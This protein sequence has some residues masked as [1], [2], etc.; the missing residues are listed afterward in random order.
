MEGNHSEP[1]LGVPS[2]QRSVRRKDD[3]AWRYITERTEQNGKKTLICD[4]CQKESGGGG[5]NRMKQHLAGIRGN[6]DSCTKVSAEVQF[7][8][9]Q[10]LKE[11]EDKNKEKR[12]IPLDDINIVADMNADGQGIHSQPSVTQ[13]KKRNRGGDLH[14]FFKTGLSDPTQPSIK[15]S[16]QSKEKVHDADMAVALWFYDACIPMNAVNS[17][18]FPVMLSKAAS[19]GHGYTGPSYHALRVGLLRDAKKHVSLIVESFRSTWASTGCTLMGDGWKDTRKRP[20]INFLVYCPKGVTFIK[21]VDASD[22]Y[23][24]A[25]NLCN[26]FAEMVEMVGSENVV[27]LVTD[28]APNYKASGRLLAERY[29]NISWSPCAAHCMNLILEDVGNMPNVKELVSAVSKVTIFV[30][31]HKSTLNFLRKRQG[32]REII[33]PGETRFATTFIALQSAYAH[34]DDLQALVVDQEF[35]QFLKTEKARCVKAV[36]LDENMWAHCLLIVRIM[37]PMIRLLRVCD[38]DEKPSL[39]YVYEGMYR[40]RLGIKKIFGKKKELYKPYTRIIKNRWDKMLRHDLHAAAYFFNPAFMYDQKNFSKKP[41]ILKG[42]LNLMEKQK[43]S[44][45]TKIFEGMTIYREREK[46]FSHSSALSCSKT[47]RPDEWWKFFG[48]DVPVLQKLAIRILS[49]TASSSGCERNWSVFERIHTKRRN[50]L[51]H[52]R[53]ND[54]VYVHYNL[55]LQDRFS[56]R[57]RSYDP[58]DYESIDKTEFWVVEE[59]GEA[60]LDYDELENALTEEN[61]KDGEDATS[62]TLNLN[63]TEDEVPFSQD[64]TTE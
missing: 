26:L 54:L 32:W 5:I 7:Q 27:H 63:G 16:I 4:F 29:P 36:V 57:K 12:G 15:A 64:D 44:D 58:I 59:S 61:P 10:S 46:S 62:E 39:P 33:R 9:K 31:N 23:T 14:G 30:Y 28:N 51:E 17:P 50:R 34:K 19:L 55:R 20:L 45:R 41:E 21:S 3:I 2:S 43:G 6:I 35:R 42:M 24:N 49:Q 47:T 13:T 1:D 18:F 60:E 37:A 53:L 25:E 48:Y 40:A 11:N 56:K 52:Q 8:M 38:T 22:V